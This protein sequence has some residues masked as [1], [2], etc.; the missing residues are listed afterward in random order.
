[1]NLPLETT[2]NNSL[3]A[4]IQPLSHFLLDPANA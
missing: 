2:F 3:I 4:P 1:M